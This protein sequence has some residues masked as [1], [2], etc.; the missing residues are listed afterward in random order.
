MLS[1][2]KSRRLPRRILATYLISIFKS[3]CAS[4]I[5]GEQNIFSTTQIRYLYYYLSLGG[6][7]RHIPA[8]F[9]TPRL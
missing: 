2:P 5:T 8:A 3:H 7:I 6:L 4:P 9:P 1:E